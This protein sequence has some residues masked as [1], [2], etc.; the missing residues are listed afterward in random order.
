MMARI[1]TEAEM[2]AVID[3]YSVKFPPV[4]AVEQM[5]AEIDVEPQAYYDAIT[6][7]AAQIGQEFDL[8]GALFM[9]G[10]AVASRP[11]QPPDPVV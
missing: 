10:V 1:E 9:M 11:E 3:A 2:K 8:V 4:D 6:N 5:C 7:L